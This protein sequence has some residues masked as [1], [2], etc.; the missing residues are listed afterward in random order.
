[1]RI[2]RTL[3][4]QIIQK[5][6]RLN[7]T[8]AKRL[9]SYI[10]RNGIKASVYKVIERLDRD[11]AEKTYSDDVF[12]LIDDK[13]RAELIRNKK[14]T[15]SYKFSIIVPA[16]ETGKRRFIQMLESC[17]DQVYDNFEICIADASVT[18]EINNTVIEYRNDFP[19]K[20]SKIK[21]VRLAENK[22]ISENTNE[23]LKLAEGEYI[24]LLDH[25]DVI[26]PDALFEAMCVLEEGL[27][28]EN[29][30]RTN[31]I[32]LIYSDEDKCNDDLNEYFDYHL[33]PDFDI[34][35][36]RT[37]NYICHLLFVRRELAM[38]VGGFLKEYDGAQDHD[39][40][41]RCVEKLRRDEIAHIPRILYHWRSHVSSTATNP[42][43]KLYAYEAGKRAV[44]DHLKRLGIDSEVTDTEHLGFYRV[45]YK[46]SAEDLTKVKI[47]SSSE[48]N[49]MGYEAVMAGDFSYIMILNDNMR[50]KNYEFIEEMAG[51]LKREEV[52]CV[53]GLVIGKNGKIESAGYSIDNNLELI[54][55]FAGLNRNYSGYLHRAKLQR[56]VDGVCTDCMMVKK[57]ALTEELALKKDY[58]VIYSPYSIFKR[59]K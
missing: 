28:L 31:R 14:F 55:C 51:Y 32:K 37:N 38:S 53:G 20:S 34:D 39:F 6:N 25:D 41:L 52:G 2:H 30:I 22:G 58:L 42:D 16:Y 57:S 7:K 44:T 12:N 18:D 50:P 45:K 4:I 26:T 33:K 23:A 43:S 49:E 59:I 1:M 47:M 24:V 15:H 27:D 5:M 17:F 19:E 35:L 56:E 54:P 29:G 11:N 3:K 10:K 21:Y 9:Y 48:L 36:L 8:D 46:V 40:I 13:E